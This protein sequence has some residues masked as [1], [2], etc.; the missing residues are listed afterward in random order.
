MKSPILLQCVYGSNSTLPAVGQDGNSNAVAMNL[1]LE[2]PAFNWQGMDREE[3]SAGVGHSVDAIL[4][5][6]SVLCVNLCSSEVDVTEVI[7]KWL[8]ISKRGN[9]LI[10]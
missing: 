2:G 3:I 5:V 4:R 8:T 1:Q 9:G 6:E 7:I 10:S